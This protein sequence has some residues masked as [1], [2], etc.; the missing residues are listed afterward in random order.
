MDSERG[1]GVKQIH[2]VTSCTDR[3]LIRVPEESRLGG[4][5]ES[6]LELRLE[7]WIERLVSIGGQPVPA[8]ELYGGE[9]WVEFLRLLATGFKP[10][11]KVRGWVISA[12]YGLVPVD[13]LV[14]PYGATF[15]R[16]NPDS[17]RP[18]AAEWTEADWW[19]GLAHWEGPSP[20]EPRTLAGL[21]AAVLAEPILVGASATYLRAVEADLVTLMDSRPA[22]EVVVFG[23]TLPASIKIRTDAS[24][25][26][27]SRL[28]TALGGSRIGL[29]IRTMSHA[30]SEAGT[31]S[32]QALAEVVQ[33][34]MVTLPEVEHPNRATSSDRDV[35]AFIRGVLR[36]N[37]DARPSPLLREWRSMNRAC[38]QGRFRSLFREV[39]REQRPAQPSELLV[40]LES[41]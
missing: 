26:Y 25:T 29:N 30:L 16:G 32:Q 28:Q 12:A 10:G 8:G 20:E 37:R 11:L 31:V 17:V 5:R 33:S 35:R 6:C 21:G 14:H 13:A 38:E 40:E 36:E 15:G 7:K 1:R 27:D 24:I 3:K 18:P 19:S 9:H 41:S 2:V 4:I 23:S 34:L 39:Y 22:G